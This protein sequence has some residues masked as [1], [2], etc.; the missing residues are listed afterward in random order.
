MAIHR[1]KWHSLSQYSMLTLLLAIGVFAPAQRS[2]GQQ[3]G[4][5]HA[6]ITNQDSLKQQFLKGGP[7]QSELIGPFHMPSFYWKLTDSLITVLGK[8]KALAF[9]QSALMDS[10][11][12]VVFYA[13]IGSVHSGGDFDNIPGRTAETVILFQNDCTMIMKP[14]EEAVRIALRN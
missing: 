12:G 11:V 6:T 2:F 13:A 14:L 7:C 10:N 8:E 3:Q 1:D 9:F 5:A 4:A